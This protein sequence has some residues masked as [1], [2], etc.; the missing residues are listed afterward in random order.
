MLI[1]AGV[2][3]GV[4]GLSAA[5]L[6]R[7]HPEADEVELAF[8]ISAAGTS[9]RSGAGFIPRY[10]SS[11]AHHRTF[12]AELGGRW[13]TRTCFEIGAEERGWLSDELVAGR[14]VRLGI[15]FRERPL[16]ALFI[17]LNRF[18]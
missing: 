9:S 2:V 3:P 6:L 14:A 5:D 10:L 1:H 12:E 8:T 18:A 16:Q 13:G 17:A 7:L 4:T 11:A 15:Y